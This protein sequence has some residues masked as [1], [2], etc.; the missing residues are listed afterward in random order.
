MFQDMNSSKAVQE[1]FRNSPSY[2]AH[3]N[4]GGSSSGGSGGGVEV[5]VHVL[6]TGYWPLTPSPPCTLPP[7][8][9]TAHTAFNSF[10]LGANSGKKLTWLTQLGS[11]DIRASFP[12]GRKELSV[13]LYQAAILLLFNE[14]EVLS[15]EHISRQAGV[16]G[17]ELRRHL[18]S[19]CTPKL[20]VLKK[21]SKSKVRV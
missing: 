6:T 12:S 7:A 10:Y 4:A 20:R 17:D 2:T 16:P 11:V 13:S 15:L 3:I 5:Q 1:D 8:I 19:L 21:S 9:Q 14:S 18:L